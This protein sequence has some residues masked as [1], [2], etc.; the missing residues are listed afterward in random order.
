MSDPIEEPQDERA[1]V[2]GTDPD[3]NIGGDDAAAG[4]GEGDDEEED[5]DRVDVADLP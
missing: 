3:M 1:N 5:D 2:A 4:S